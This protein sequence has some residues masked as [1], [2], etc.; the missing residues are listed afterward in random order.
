MDMRA[1]GD[2]FKVCLCRNKTKKEVIDF[3]RENEIK[4]LSRYISGFLLDALAGVNGT[5]GTDQTAE[6]T[7][8]TL[9]ANNTG[10]AR[11]QVKDNGL[12]PTV[13]TRYLTTATAH[14]AFTVD[15]GI[16]HCGAVKM[17]GRGETGELGAHKVL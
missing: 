17:G 14:T 15:H 16:D 12:M 5:C 4:T 13:S 3:I 9:G 2:D 1:M 11:V 6:M 8:H 10:L 7:A